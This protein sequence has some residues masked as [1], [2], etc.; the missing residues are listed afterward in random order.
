MAN[1]VV[2]LLSTFLSRPLSSNVV[3]VLGTEYKTDNVTNVTPAIINKVGR[4]LHNI[5]Q[6]PI[7]IVKQRVVDHFYKH[8]TTNTGNAVFSHI[9]NVSPIVTIE[10]NFDSLLVP[11]NHPCRNR[12][13]NY[14]VNAHHALRS[15]TSAHQRDFV[16]MGLDSFLVTGDVYRRDEIDSS[17]YPVFHQME[18]VRL[19]TRHQLFGNNSDIMDLFDIE[20]GQDTIEKQADHT[21]DTAKFLELD[22]KQTLE[23]L[24]KD[25]FGR[26]TETRWSSCY[27]PFTHPSYELEIKFKGEWME[28]L[29][30]GVMRQEILRHGGAETKVGWA[31][32]LG[33]DRL[34]MLMFNIPDIR[35]LWSEDKRFIDQFKGVGIDPKSNVKF[36]PYSKFPACFKDLSFWLDEGYHQNDLYE[37][38]RNVGGDKIEKVELIDTFEDSKTKKQSHCYRITYRSMDRS[39][40]NEEINQLQSNIRD[41]VRDK[42]C[43]EL[44]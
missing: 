12:N 17:H 2:R 37:I 27:F 7:N 30:S 11:P 4:N 19:F 24:V 3:S 34:S 35:L 38:V 20:A 21:F 5:P 9:D 18:G 44:R 36:K 41:N 28:V 26:D 32:G 39:L 14:Y 15:H 29:G 6:H 23:N 10:Q 42:L 1:V 13:D 16:K 8:Y 33:L 43:V 31:F 40:A 25:I 22:L